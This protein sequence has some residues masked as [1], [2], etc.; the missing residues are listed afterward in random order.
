MDSNLERKITPLF[1]TPV[2]NHII[3]LSYEVNDAVLS[4]EYERTEANN[5]CMTK[6]KNLLDDPRLAVLRISLIKSVS[7]F[8]HTAVGVDKN[9]NFKIINSWANRH[10]PGDY[11]QLHHHAN[12]IISGVV[13][14]ITPENSGNL[15]F[16]KNPIIP[17][18]WTST[19]KLDLDEHAEKHIINL[20]TFDVKPGR[21]KCI[22]FPSHLSHSVTKNLSI[23]DRYTIA[24]NVFVEGTVGKDGCDKLEL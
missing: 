23:Q 14:V 3:N 5:G 6:N 18:L 24:F 19:V 20:E 15:R 10:K 8:M 4:A 16:H 1:S 11:A 7:E 12:S 21:G 9:I 13:F 2:F 22:L 17:T